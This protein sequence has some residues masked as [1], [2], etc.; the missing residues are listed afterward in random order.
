LT[1]HWAIDTEAT[2]TPDGKTIIFTS[3]RSGKPQLYRTPVGG[4]QVQRLT[5]EGTENARA[6]VSPDGRYVAMAHKNSGDFIAL[7]DLKTDQLQVLPTQ[8]HFAESPSFAPNG[9]M[10]IYATTKGNRAELAAVSVDGRITQSLT[11]DDDVRDPA[12]SPLNKK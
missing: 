4:G 2:W 9:S 1:H 8:G 6:C 12:W 3:D 10:I 5:F 11:Y 7:L